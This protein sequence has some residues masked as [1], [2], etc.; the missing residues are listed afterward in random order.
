[1][2][3]QQDRRRRKVFVRPPPPLPSGSSF[4]FRIK[5]TSF[6]S[7]EGGSLEEEEDASG[8]GD[9]RSLSLSLSLSLHE[10]RSPVLSKEERGRE[11]ERE[12][13]PQG[14]GRVESNPLHPYRE[15]APLITSINS[16]RALLLLLSPLRLKQDT[17]IFFFCGFSNE[18]THCIFTLSLLFFL[19][20]VVRA[21][22]SLTYRTLQG[23][24][25]SRSGQRQRREKPTHI[26]V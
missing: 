8:D 26:S 20:Q 15:E 17:S 2:C 10:T 5:T 25:Y 21:T 19:A 13:C 11:R 9:E 14:S 7:K 24:Q 12:R 6:H 18:V 22:F 16:V 3:I 4:M 23:Q 1:M